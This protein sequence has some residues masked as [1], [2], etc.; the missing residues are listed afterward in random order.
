MK[1]IIRI[2][3]IIYIFVIFTLGPKTNFLTC[4]D[5]LSLSTQVMGL[6]DLN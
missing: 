4:Y 2:V 6:I 3:K 5:F 1:R